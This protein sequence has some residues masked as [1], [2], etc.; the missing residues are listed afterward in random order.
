MLDTLCLSFHGGRGGIYIGDVFVRL[1]EIA[2]LIGN[3][4]RRRKIFFSSCDTLNTPEKRIGLFMA[5][6]N[7]RRIAGYE[8][9]VSIKQA[10]KNDKKVLLSFIQDTNK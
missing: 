9:A 2:D 5:D 3:K 8:D 1:E 7:I 4:G 10:T 6:T